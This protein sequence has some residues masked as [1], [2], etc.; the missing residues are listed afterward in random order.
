MP[1]SFAICSRTVVEARA[2]IEDVAGTPV[3]AVVRLM[4]ATTAAYR[5]EPAT[6]F[7]RSAHKD[8]G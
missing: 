3:H 4:T 7:D 2:D 5:R 8:V 1:P 6:Q